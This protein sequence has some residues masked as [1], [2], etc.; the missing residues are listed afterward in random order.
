M[1]Q[2]ADLI[3][4]DPFFDQDITQFKAVTLYSVVKRIVLKIITL[5]AL[6]ASSFKSVV[7]AL[8][9]SKLPTAR[10]LRQNMHQILVLIIFLLNNL[11][12]RCFGKE[13]KHQLEF[14]FIQSILHGI[15]VIKPVVENQIGYPLLLVFNGYSKHGLGLSF[16]FHSSFVALGRHRNLR[17]ICGLRCWLFKHTHAKSIL[18]IKNI[19]LVL[20]IYCFIILVFAF[21]AV[22]IVFTAIG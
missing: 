2:I 10:V 9:V 14:L 18:I 12:I 8:E 13:S 7:D 4:V 21:R 5:Q 15:N 17:F 20:F 1:P 19:L 6:N 16:F 22:A 3:D 11:I